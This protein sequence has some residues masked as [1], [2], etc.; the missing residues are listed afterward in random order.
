MTKY[1]IEK[2]DEKEDFNLWKTN[3]KVILNQHKATLAIIDSTKWPETIRPKERN[4]EYI[5][6][7]S[8]DFEYVKRCLEVSHRFKHSFQN[9]K[10]S[11]TSYI[12][13][14]KN[15]HNSFF[16]FLVRFFTFKMDPSKSI[17][18]NL[19]EYKEIISEFKKTGET[20]SEET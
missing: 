6:L 15:L 9:L 2:F 17:K 8:F 11:S 7:W 1:N 3:I 5:S 13:E 4:K 16:F 12:Y 19:D 14:S 20:V 10:T 18:E